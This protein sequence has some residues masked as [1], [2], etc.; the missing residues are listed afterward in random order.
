[1]TAPAFKD[2]EACKPGELVRFSDKDGTHWA[3]VGARGNERLLLLVL[4]RDREPYCM[5]L[6]GQMEIMKGAYGT[7]VVLSYGA[8]YSIEVDHAGNCEVGDGGTLVGTPGA[9]VL[10]VSDELICCKYED[11][12]SKKAYFNLKSGN[13]QSEPGSKRAVFAGWNLEL[14]G[15]MTSQPTVLFQMHAGKKEPAATSPKNVP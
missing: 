14:A 10:T 9:Y 3:L 12:P 7:A 15:S 6:M 2:F 11:H 13:V 4:P 8:G 1:M 5:N